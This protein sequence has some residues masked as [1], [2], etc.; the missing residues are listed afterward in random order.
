MEGKRTPACKSSQLYVVAVIRVLL[1]KRGTLIHLQPPIK[2]SL[3]P[4]IMSV[5]DLEILLHAAHQPVA[6]KFPGLNDKRR[7]TTKANGVHNCNKHPSV[8]SNIA[9]RSLVRRRLAREIVFAQILVN[10]CLSIA[11]YGVLLPPRHIIRQG[12]GPA[13][14]CV[15]KSNSS[16]TYIYSQKYILI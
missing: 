11:C 5:R 15:A 3:A 13:N 8:I 16:G 14:E 10:P 6:S 1:M 2:T 7:S 12:S 4:C 9:S